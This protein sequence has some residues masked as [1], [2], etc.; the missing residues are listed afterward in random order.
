VAVDRQRAL[1]LAAAVAL[2][3]AGVLIVVQLI[4]WDSGPPSGSTVTSSPPTTDPGLTR[5]T[6]ADFSID[7]PTGWRVARID[8][9]PKGAHYLDTTINRVRGDSSHLVRVDVIDAGDPRTV[10]N[11]ALAALRTRRGFAL[12]H[13][14]PVQLHTRSGDYDAISLA[15][16]LGGIR[17]V[18]VIFG[19]V[20]GRVFA[21]LT[22]A[23]VD[24]YDDWA[25]TYE[26]VRA[27]LRIT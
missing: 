26:R 2:V 7:Y 17:S 27:S 19:D 22:R 15:F 9:V 20:T 18:D 21:V 25:P 8:H 24:G 1:W 11:D 13:D 3:L 16:E 12:V 14:E 5:L 6:A 4:G 10:A 23:P